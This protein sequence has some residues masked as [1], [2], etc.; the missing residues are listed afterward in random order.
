MKKIPEIILPKMLLKTQLVKQDIDRYML[1]D[2]G[3]Y[4]IVHSQH[5]GDRILAKMTLMDDRKTIF[6]KAGRIDWFKNS[7]KIEMVVF[8]QE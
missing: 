2:K 5:T 3:I 1:P 4:R 7:V 8:M 6:A